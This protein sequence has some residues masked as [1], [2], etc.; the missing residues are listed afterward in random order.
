MFTSGVHLLKHDII[1]FFNETIEYDITNE[2][3]A[4]FT[5]K[6]IR[7]LIIDKILYQPINLDDNKY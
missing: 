4:R 7:I 5:E 3:L 1:F 6:I 2:E